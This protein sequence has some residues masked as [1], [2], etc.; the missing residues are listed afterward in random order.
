MNIM[1]EVEFVHKLKPKKM[2]AQNRF[3]T[4]TNCI[5]GI[6]ILPA[7]TMKKE[8]ESYLTYLRIVVGPLH[9][10]ASCKSLFG[11]RSKNSKRKNLLLDKCL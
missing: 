3:S 10:C 4:V 1:Y 8:S 6:D 9:L 5:M 11:Y 7:I 2:S